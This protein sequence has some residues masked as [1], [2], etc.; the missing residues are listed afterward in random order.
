[1]ESNFLSFLYIFDISPL[2]DENYHGR[3]RSGWERRGEGKSGEG[4]GMRRDRREA[5]TVRRMKGKALAAEPDDLR[6]IP[7]ST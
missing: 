3:Q 1:M 7:K 2:S 6:L 4:S 5:K